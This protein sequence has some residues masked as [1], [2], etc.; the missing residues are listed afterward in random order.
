[1]KFSLSKESVQDIQN[2]IR[3]EVLPVVKSAS[4]LDCLLQETIRL[5]EAMES[6][7]ASPLAAS[8]KK[9]LA[10]APKEVP[11]K[12]EAVIDSEVVENPAKTPAKVKVSPAKAFKPSLS[13]EEL[14]QKG[15]LAENFMKSLSA[16]GRNISEHAAQE[17]CLEGLRKVAFK[18]KGG[19]T[20]KEVQVVEAFLASPDFL[21]FSAAWEKIMTSI[22]RSYKG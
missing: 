16:H 8:D 12:E 7:G 22:A 18:T 19:L 17:V 3:I 9:P 13:P 20:A 1:M 6:L 2:S 14:I 10:K 4:T 5:R 21:D 11:P 15:G